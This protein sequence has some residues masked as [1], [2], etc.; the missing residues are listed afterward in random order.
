[1]QWARLYAHIQLRIYPN[2]HAHTCTC[3]RD[4]TLTR[5]QTP[6][7]VQIRIDILQGQYGLG[8]VGFTQMERVA[9]GVTDE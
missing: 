2:V 8:G 3:S 1:M 7:H 6:K 9:E 4:Q 5:I